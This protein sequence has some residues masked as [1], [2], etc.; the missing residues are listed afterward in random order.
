V[1]TFHLLIDIV[2]QITMEQ[3]DAATQ[4][5]TYS[6]WVLNGTIICQV[7]YLEHNDET[8]Q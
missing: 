7:L 1:A 5:H 8:T 4:A 2:Q 3:Y 6:P